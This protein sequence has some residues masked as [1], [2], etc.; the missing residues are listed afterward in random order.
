ML[1]ACDQPF[2]GYEA[3][4]NE[5]PDLNVIFPD[6]NSAKDVDTEMDEK[7]EEVVL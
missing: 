5:E 6:S 3:V 1:K 2:V 7:A 4:P